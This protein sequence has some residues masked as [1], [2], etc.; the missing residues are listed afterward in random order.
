MLFIKFDGHGIYCTIAAEISLR[1]VGLMMLISNPPI[2]A[3]GCSLE[4][5]AF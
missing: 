4:N 3:I 1:F 5:N 2:I